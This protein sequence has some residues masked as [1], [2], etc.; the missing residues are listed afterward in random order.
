MGFGKL[1]Y[2]EIKEYVVMW[3]HTTSSA[4][5]LWICKYFWEHSDRLPTSV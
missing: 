5:A 2:V 3:N 1:N 4:F